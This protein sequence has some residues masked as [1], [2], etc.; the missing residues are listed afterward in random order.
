MLHVSQ[1]VKKLAVEIMSQ[2]VGVSSRAEPW[3]PYFWDLVLRK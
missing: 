3:I 1:K 2:V